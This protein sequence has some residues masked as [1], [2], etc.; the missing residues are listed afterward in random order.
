M[1][2]VFLSCFSH[3]VISKVTLMTYRK[4]NPRTQ[5][6]LWKSTYNQ[7]HTSKDKL[8]F[9][10]NKYL[11]QWV[12]F[13]SPPYMYF[14]PCKMSMTN[15]SPIHSPLPWE[16]VGTF[17]LPSF[18]SSGQIFV[19]ERITILPPTWTF[20]TRTNLSSPSTTSTTRSNDHRQRGT[21]ALNTKTTSPSFTF[22]LTDCLFFLW[23]NVGINCNIKRFQKCCTKSLTCLHLLITP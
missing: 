9:R 12:L 2:I 19:I 8:V 13:C 1:V 15:I 16:T 21:S 20:T 5:Q 17:W 18:T 4:N 14:S 3:K 6:P 23:F 7:F 11:H 22:R 10:T